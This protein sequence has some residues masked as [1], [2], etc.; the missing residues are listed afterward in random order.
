MGATNTNTK[1][2][3]ALIIILALLFMVGS[4]VFKSEPWEKRENWAKLAEGMTDDE[5]ISI[6]GTPTG[7]EN[8]ESIDEMVLTYGYYQVTVTNST[9]RVKAWRGP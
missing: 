3:S 9:R 7:R 6:L 2:I 5:V 8:W 1:A 4:C